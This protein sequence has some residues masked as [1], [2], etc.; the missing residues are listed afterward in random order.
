MPILRTQEEIDACYQQL[1]QELGPLDAIK[2]REWRR[3]ER[4][5]RF[6]IAHGITAEKQAKVFAKIEAQQ[7]DF[8][9]RWRKVH[10][11]AVIKALFD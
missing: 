3:L 2:D 10:A 1:E 7:A 5:R 11:K 9:E 8:V 6:D 4:I